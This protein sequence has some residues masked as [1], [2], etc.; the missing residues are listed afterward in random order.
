MK[1]IKNIDDIK[2]L[3]NEVLD[4]DEILT[5]K[6]NLYFYYIYKDYNDDFLD[7]NSIIKILQSNSPLEKFYEIINDMYI[8]Y[9]LSI[10][11]EIIDRVI[12]SLKE[13]NIEVE[14]KENL[15]DYIGDIIVIE[16]PYKDYLNHML[17]INVLVDTGDGNYDYSLNTDINFISNNIN[18]KNSILWLSK[19]QGFNKKDLFNLLNKKTVTKNESKFEKTIYE[20]MINAINSMNVLTF[21]VK[22]SLDDLI[23]INEDIKKKNALFIIKKNTNAGLVDYWN[24]GGSLLNISL[25]RDV[26]IPSKY[27]DSISIDGDRGNYSVSDIYGCSNSLWNGDI[28]KA[29]QKE[30]KKWSLDLKHINKSK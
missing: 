29:N 11:E 10:Q 4:K 24:G 19:T 20:E 3:I 22:M 30:I 28:K 12:S 25:N 18:N 2:D 9:D 23:K 14:D 6:N 27:I 7:D 26:L 17:Q 15:Y 13:I 21:F 1:K 16:Y 5:K 8:D